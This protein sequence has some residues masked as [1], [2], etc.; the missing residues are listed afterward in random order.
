MR[1]WI[2]RL[3]QLLGRERLEAG[4]SEE[5]SF[6]VEARTADLVRR[7]ASPEEAQRQARAEFGSRERYREETRAALGFRWFDELQQDLRFGV[8]SL[9]RSKGFTATVI[10]TLALGIGA[11]TAI[12]SLVNGVMLRPLP[13]RDPDRL[14]LLDERPPDRSFS[15]QNVGFLPPVNFFARRDQIHSFESF[16]ALQ[17]ARYQWIGVEDPE[18]LK[19]GL[20]SADLCDAL[21][22]RPPIGRCLTTEDEA[23]RAPVAMI[24]HA[25]WLRRFGGDP[26]VL[27]RTLTLRD[28]SIKD[29]P[30]TVVGVLPAG[31]RLVYECD[32]FVPY[33]HNPN[34][35]NPAS[36]PSVT[37]GRLRPGLTAAEAHTELVSLQQS[38]YP[39]KYEQHGGNDIEVVP[40]QD[41]IAQPVRSGLALLLGVV[42][43]LLLISCANIANLL[44]SRGSTRAREVAVRA[45]VGAGRWRVC[46]QLLTESLL[47]AGAGGAAGWALAFALL[48]G[49]LALATQRLPRAAEISM[50]GSVL[51]FALAVSIAT[52]LLFGLL[53]ALRLSRVDLVDA[54]KSGGAGALGGRG[55]H[56]LMSGLL[57][58]QTALCVIAMVGAG[59]LL[60]TFV[61]L[62][63]ID[64]GFRADNVVAVQLNLPNQAPAAVAFL[65]RVLE[66]VRALP[67]VEA[68]A[69]TDNPPPYHVLSVFDFRREG[70]DDQYGP[71]GPRAN[72]RRV[73]PGY[74]AAMAIPLLR[75]RG[76]DRRDGADSVP[77]AAIVSQSLARHYWPDQ[78]PL[79]KV[80]FL[81]GYRKETAAQVIGVAGDVRQS[82]LAREPDD[83]LY[84]SYTQ[85]DRKPET[86][87]IRTRSSTAGLIPTIRSEIRA[88]DRNQTL[89][90]ETLEDLLAGDIAE[91]R[92]YMILL[93]GFATLALLL[94]AV[95]IGGLVAYAVSR[96]RQ[97]IGLRISFGA[98][99]ARLLRM[100]CAGNLRLVAV[101]VALG[102]AGS[103]GVTRFAKSLLYEVTPTDPAT[104]AA[105]ALVLL[106][107]ALAACV[108]ASVR[109]TRLD[110]V[111][112]L[113]Q[114]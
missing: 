99:P 17:A 84:L 22:I 8:R 93:T 21:G 5:M 88:I 43:L 33:S 114:D 81:R 58:F 45:S 82:G 12:F 66:R 105:A 71:Q 80:I 60:N 89:T 69:A 37:I 7:G 96:R 38:L 78:D 77:H 59:L 98:T 56:R 6:H 29:V 11:T 68:A 102:A 10:G 74:F 75:G 101:G 27:G 28:F 13:F 72:T 73:T 44:L 108:A 55:Q 104:F 25:L 61:R 64:P 1:T 50:D 39:Q 34:Y 42:G 100:F 2:K 94:T 53:P 36:S 107:A 48:R 70:T 111:S 67:G 90:T 47:L 103:L 65:D 46:R 51:V 15:L 110:P 86:L 106:G 18:Y 83:Q 92:F 95:G 30:F 49:I 40:L 62:R 113:R 76:F 85:A 79:G 23:T 41:Y 31:F 97:E 91:Q 109:A 26:Q 54:V 35:S 3:R 32:V 57:V 19:G 87:M 52:G 20:V 4:L 24:S 63:A 14:M 9:R 16:A 112:V